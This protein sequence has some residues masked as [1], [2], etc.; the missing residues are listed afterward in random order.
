MKNWKG[1]GWQSLC[2]GFNSCCDGSL[3]EKSETSR[4]YDV[5]YYRWLSNQFLHKVLFVLVLLTVFILSSSTLWDNRRTWG[6]YGDF[7]YCFHI[8]GER[9]W[10][11]HVSD[12]AHQIS[13]DK[14]TWGHAEWAAQDSSKLNHVWTVLTSRKM[15]C[16][17]PCA[18]LNILGTTLTK[19]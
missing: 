15:L 3:P 17:S 10:K 6:S 9:R 4:S 19:T 2:C 7:I 8:Y 18:I 16:C 11:V 1:E 5:C 13:Y 14:N 12:I